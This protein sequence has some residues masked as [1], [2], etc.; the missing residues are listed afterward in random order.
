MLNFDTG[1]RDA[2]GT[3]PIYGASY[4]R[5]SL[6][7]SPRI[8]NLICLFIYHSAPE[9]TPWHEPDLKSPKYLSSPANSDGL[10]YICVARARKIRNDEVR[11]PKRRVFRAPTPMGSASAIA[12]PRSTSSPE[13]ASL[14]SGV[15]YHAPS[16]T[17]CGLG[18]SAERDAGALGAPLAD[19]NGEAVEEWEV[20]RF[21]NGVPPYVLRNHRKRVICVAQQK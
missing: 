5:L 2:Q 9:A 6:G 19:R 21:C 14:R 20:S 7:Q 8:I 17:S 3:E 10:F 18:S 11:F 16:E 13:R 4:R 1:P 12:R 15:E